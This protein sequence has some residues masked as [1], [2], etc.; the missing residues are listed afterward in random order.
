MEKNKILKTLQIVDIKSS[1]IKNWIQNESLQNLSKIK[2]RNLFKNKYGFNLEDD[3]LIPNDEY[4]ILAC[5]KLNL[6]TKDLKSLFDS[7]I[8]IT[9]K[10]GTFDT[11]H[12]FLFDI[13]NETKEIFVQNFDKIE[14]DYYDVLC[15]AIN[16]DLELKLNWN[17]VFS[18]L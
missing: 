16:N 10:F 1:I 6:F 17:L 4:L 11:V 15:L 14:K 3:N 9:N 12:E 5:M 2:T 8:S 7:N 18:V 13:I